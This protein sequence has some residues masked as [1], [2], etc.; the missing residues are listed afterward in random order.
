MSELKYRGW[1]VILEKENGKL[2]TVP[3]ILFG[4]LALGT[5]AR[6]YLAE[7]DP[8]A[9]PAPCNPYSLAPTM[10]QEH[11]RKD[12]A[13]GRGVDHICWRAIDGEIWFLDAKGGR[14][15]TSGSMDMTDGMWECPHRPPWNFRTHC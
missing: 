14:A 6:M 4:L 3:R 9:P 12:L 13:A 11:L 15:L 10:S 7:P 5:V 8:P 2:G 1:V